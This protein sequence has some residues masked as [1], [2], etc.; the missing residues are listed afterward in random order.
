MLTIGTMYCSPTKA[1]FAWRKV[2]TLTIPSSYVGVPQIDVDLDVII[3]P[4]EPF[5]YLG[6]DPNMN[7]YKI[8]TKD[9]LVRWISN[10]IN[11]R[12][13]WIPCKTT[14]LNTED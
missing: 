9:S 6:F 10:L 8:L 11:D 14:T 3:L 1:M 4:G 5:V 13:Q 12:S 2:E 7:W